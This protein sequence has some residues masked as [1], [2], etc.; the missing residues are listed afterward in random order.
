M[1]MSKSSNLYFLNNTMLAKC[2][3]KALELMPFIQ[4]IY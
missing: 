1:Y 3:L 2:F 4:F